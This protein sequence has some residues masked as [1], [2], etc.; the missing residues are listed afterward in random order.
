M[1]RVL[2]IGAVNFCLTQI[3]D[4]GTDVLLTVVTYKLLF[5][6]LC[7]TVPTTI[8][9]S[10]FPYMRHA[11]GDFASIA[12]VAPYAPL[13]SPRMKVYRVLLVT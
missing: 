9:H 8:T 6:A 5:C 12:L 11:Y 4:V 10:D 7:R 13:C 1:F 2:F 3:V